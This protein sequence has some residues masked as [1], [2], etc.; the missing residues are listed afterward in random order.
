MRKNDTS[1]PNQKPTPRPDTQRQAHLEQD[2]VGRRL[3]LRVDLGE[4]LGERAAAGHA[5]PHPGAD[6]GRGEADRDHAVEEREQQDPPSRR[7]TACGRGPG[8]AAPWSWRQLVDASL[9]PKPVITP[10]NTITRKTPI[11][12]IDSEHRERHVAP[13]VLASPRPAGRRPPSRSG[14]HVNTIASVK[15]GDRVPMLPGLNGC[16][17]TAAGR[18]A[19][20]SPTGASSEHDAASRSRR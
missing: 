4:R 2:R 16:E 17:E 5:V 13:R 3:V 8:P 9:T 14:L 11:R 15:P 1:A 18:R 12:V 20:G 6:V 19:R 7:P 10:Q